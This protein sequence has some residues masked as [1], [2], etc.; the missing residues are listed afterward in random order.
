MQVLV[1]CAV[2]GRAERAHGWKAAELRRTG[3]PQRLRNPRSRLDVVNNRAAAM[4]A[5]VLRR[6]VFRREVFSEVIDLL[7]RAFGF[8][9]EAACTHA[10]C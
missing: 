7:W 4:S 6:G 1:I 8:V 2:H 3:L 5:L 10:F 9:T